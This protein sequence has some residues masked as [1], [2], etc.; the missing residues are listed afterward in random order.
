MPS[1]TPWS[2]CPETNSQAHHR[3]R[4]LPSR[5]ILHKSTS[6]LERAFEMNKGT[7]HSQTDERSMSV[8]QRTK[9][10]SKLSYVQHG[11]ISVQ[12]VNQGKEVLQP[13]EVAGQ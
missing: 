4:Y 1:A 12:E 11:K 3:Q 2:G 8:V 7:T 9:E 10:E 6:G 13:A 5:E